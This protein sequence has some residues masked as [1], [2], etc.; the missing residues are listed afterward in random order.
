MISVEAA[1]V[2]PHGPGHARQRV[3]YGDS[4]FVEVRRLGSI[5]ALTND[6]VFRA[7][8]EQVLIP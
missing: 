6:A 1:A 8:T 3:G 7:F 4:G 5:R 2:L